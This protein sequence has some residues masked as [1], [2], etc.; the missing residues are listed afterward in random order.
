[1]GIGSAIWKHLK[2]NKM[3][4]GMGGYFGYE[5]YNEKRQEGAGTV[6]AAA[7]G[8][9][10]AV[11]PMMISMPAYIGYELA[12]GIPTMAVEGTI[13]ANQYKRKLAQEARGQAFSNA[14]F[15]D[16]QQAYT[17]RQAGMAIAERS[18]Y[19]IN[20]AMLGNEAKYMMK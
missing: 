19:N 9:F 17:M 8:A 18:K 12:T 13:A 7:A 14:K 1:M 16:T 10:E 4:I 15:N 6:T 2:N 5:T 20:Q 3:N 11:L